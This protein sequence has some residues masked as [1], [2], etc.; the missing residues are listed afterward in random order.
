MAQ[1]KKAKPTAKTTTATPTQTNTDWSTKLWLI[2]VILGVLIFAT[3]LLNVLTGIDDHT[4]TTDNPV[5]KD[6]SFGTLFT[7]FNLGMYAPITWLGYAMAHAMAGAQGKNPVPYHLLSLIVHAF[8]IYMVFRLVVKLDFQEKIALG[9]ALLFAIHPLQVESVSWIAGFSTPLFSMFYLM[10]CLRY[11]DYSD[12]EGAGKLRFYALS[13]LFF[14]LACLS[15]SAAVTLP[16]LLALIDQW[17]KPSTDFTRRLIAYLPY[18][19]MAIGFGLLTV[20]SRRHSGMNVGLD[21]GIEGPLERLLVV[22]FTPIFYFAKTFFPYKLN[23]YYAFNEVN[24]TLP[25]PYYAACAALLGLGIAAWYWRK[26]TPFLWL[27]LLFFMINISVMLPFR[28]LGTFELIADHYNYLAIIGVGLVLVSAWVALQERYPSAAPV[29]RGVGYLWVGLLVL[30]S[31]K[32]IRI[33]KNT[34]SVITNAI[35]NGYYQHGMMY[36]GRG[37]EYGDQGKTQEA[38]Q[39][40]SRAIELDST[41]KDAYKFRGS[42]YAQARRLPEAQKD[43]E[44]FVS[45]DDKDVVVWHNLA[46]LYMNTNQTQKS[47]NAFNKTIAL[48]PEAAVT[49]SK[50]AKLYEMMGDTVRQQ[51]DL[52]KA[53]ELATSKKGGLNPN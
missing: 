8:N 50:R 47:L 9:V 28:P 31:L 41:M 33:W 46:M 10:A 20:Y 42:I 14:L 25:W 16:V 49:Y 34:E 39:D 17:R 15:K 26:Q 52:R 44:K 2:P 3:G 6:F 22:G 4:A 32:Q 23:I 45:F 35:N 1:Q 21:S 30:M 27:G 40:F 24:G 43:L 13:L 11:I 48:K 29:I 12:A 5:V 38:V 18:F 36:F 7:N 53:K 51:A 37:L 19:L